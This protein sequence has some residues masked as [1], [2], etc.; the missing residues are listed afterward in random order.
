MAQR[1]MQVLPYTYISTIYYAFIQPF[2]DYGFSVWG[3]T[4][5]LNIKKVQRLQSRAAPVLTNNFNYEISSHNILKQQKWQN[6]EKRKEFLTCI[7]MYKCVNN[8]AP[9]YLSDDILYANQVHNYMTRNI[10]ND[11]LYIPQAR[12][13]Y[14]KKSLLYIGPKLWNELPISIR[15]VTTIDHFKRSLK[16]WQC[17]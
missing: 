9:F 17:D 14:F 15:S 7:L 5:D 6:V 11:H 10:A 8:S 13:E 1:L 2:I 4:S 12:T 16:K 3:N